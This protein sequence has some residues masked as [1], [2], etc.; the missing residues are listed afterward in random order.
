MHKKQ[1]M[2]KKPAYS[3]GQLLLEN[4]FIDEQQFHVHA[5]YEHARNL[6]GFGVVHGLELSRAGTMAVSVSPGYAVDRRGREIELQSAQTLELNQLAPGTQAW[7]TI[8]F[9]GEPVVASH[10]A[11]RRI[12]CFAVLRVDTGIEEHD[13]RLG[14]VQLDAKG[15]LTA[16]PGTEER[17][18]LRTRLAPGSVTSEALAPH[19]LRGWISMPFHPSDIPADDAHTCPPFR[20][21]ATQARTHDEFG[22][23]PNTQGGGGTMP[24]ALPIGIRSIHRL[25]IAGAVNEAT[26]RVVLVRGSFDTRK[27]QHTREELVSLSV[28]SGPYTQTAQIPEEH[29]H[30]GQQPHRTL[31]IDIRATGRAAVSFVALDVSY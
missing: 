29:R 13:V 9:R 31:A 12:D 15:Q 24:I 23:K 2:G 22:G 21:G 10:D 7:V 18:V 16:D 25:R 30:I 8:G 4:D 27:M 19:L 28:P 5:R 26:M 20:V 6:H 14:S 1:L 3:N 17:D 11:P